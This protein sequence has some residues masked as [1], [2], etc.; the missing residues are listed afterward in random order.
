MPVSEYFKG[1]GSKVMSSMQKRYGDKKGKSVFYA[2]ANK[3][4]LKP[5]STKGSGPGKKRLPTTHKR[6]TKRA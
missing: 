6:G 4:G 3:Q 5:P 2:T 1:S